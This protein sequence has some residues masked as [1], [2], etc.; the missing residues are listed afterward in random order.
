MLGKSNMDEFAMG[1]SNETSY[2]GPVKNP[3][4]TD[5]STRRIVRRLGGG[6]GRPAGAVLDRHRY[7]RFDPPARR[8]DGRDRASNPPTDGSRATG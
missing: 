7:R 6:V 8:P 1:S 2:Y 4:D 5:Q 3:W